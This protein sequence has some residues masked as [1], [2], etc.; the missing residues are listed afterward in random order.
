MH[1]VCGAR[2]VTQHSRRQAIQCCC[3]ESRDTVAITMSTTVGESSASSLNRVASIWRN[4]ALEIQKP[5][6]SNPRLAERSSPANPV[7]QA[8]NHLPPQETAPAVPRHLQ[9]VRQDSMTLS[10]LPVATPHSAG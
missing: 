7:R 2:S 9:P 5:G 10:D 6:N 1:Y 3:L 4:Q 8:P